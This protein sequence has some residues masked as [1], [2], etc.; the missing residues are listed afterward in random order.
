M[1]KSSLFGYFI[2][3]ITVLEIAASPDLSV[4]TGAFMLEVVKTAIH[5]AIDF[6]E[7]EQFG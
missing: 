7:R 2:Q 3:V 6:T 5:L 4:W 1:Y